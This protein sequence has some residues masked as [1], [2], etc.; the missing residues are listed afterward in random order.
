MKKVLA[1]R[2]MKTLKTKR[3]SRAKTQR[4]KENLKKQE[5]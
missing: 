1:Q 5:D 2:G 3:L 4:R